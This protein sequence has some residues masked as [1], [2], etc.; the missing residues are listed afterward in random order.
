VTGSLR[1]APADTGP[2]AAIR[3]QFP[4]WHAW[5]SSAGRFWAVRT[6]RRGRPSGAP[7]EWAMTV[8]GDT[9]GDL[10]AA[11][12]QQEQLADSG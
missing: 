1:A 4:R 5:R 3:G 2:L 6:D 12:A 11:I 7:A 10:T 8:D 9:A